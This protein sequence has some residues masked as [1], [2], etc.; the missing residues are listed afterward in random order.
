MMSKKEVYDDFLNHL[1]NRD[2]A[3]LNSEYPRRDNVGINNKIDVKTTYLYKL[4]YGDKKNMNDVWNKLFTRQE[5]SIA[6]EDEDDDDDFD[7]KKMVRRKLMKHLIDPEKKSHTP[8]VVMPVHLFYNNPSLNV[9]DARKI[10][11]YYNKYVVFL[12]F[13]TARNLNLK[14][15][16]DIKGPSS[17]TKTKISLIDDKKSL[18]NESKRKLCKL[19]SQKKTSTIIQSTKQINFKEPLQDDKKKVY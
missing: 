15:K 12:L 11:C 6:E 13:Y 19:Q 4:L 17:F 10:I 8:L 16:Q 5:L 3:P 14:I 7:E 1:T 18:I 9:K 2:L